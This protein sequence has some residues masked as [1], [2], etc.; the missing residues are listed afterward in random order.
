MKKV[1]FILFFGS[2]FSQLFAIEGQ[3]IQ[4]IKTNDNGQAR[5][6]SANISV[7]LEG[8]TIEITFGSDC[9]AADI[10]VETATGATVAS[11]YCPST[12]GYAELTISTPGCY[13]LTITTSDGIYKGQLIIN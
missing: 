9:G 3:P 8:N 6:Q 10:T 2:L 1:L 11:T 12:P 4:L 5:T 7:E 13:V